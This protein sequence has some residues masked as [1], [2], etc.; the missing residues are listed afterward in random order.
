MLLHGIEVRMNE[1]IL[2]VTFGTMR[3]DDE[4]TQGYNLVKWIMES[5]TVQEDTVLMGVEPQP[6]AFTGEIICDA[7][8]WNPVP[9]AIDWYTPMFKREGLVIIRLKQVLI[10]GMTMKM[11]SDNNMLPN[12]CN[13]KQATNQGA[14]KID[15]DNVCEIIEEVYRRDKFDKEFNIG[16]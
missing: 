9:N 3:T 15:G 13:K 8:F 14:M 2:I 7:V 4:T 1:R 11:I 12:K 6:S 5:Y 16:F 10:T